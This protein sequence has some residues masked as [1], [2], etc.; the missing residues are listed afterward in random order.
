MIKNKAPKV[1]A[2]NFA[3][4]LGFLMKFGYVIHIGRKIFHKK[5]KVSSS[6]NDRVIKEKPFSHSSP[7]LY[8][9]TEAKL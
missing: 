7:G 6:K 8:I 5:L 9:Q 3:S 2:H 1:T 4:V